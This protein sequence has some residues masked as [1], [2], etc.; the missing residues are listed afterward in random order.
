[1]AESMP[2][3]ETVSYGKFARRENDEAADVRWEHLLDDLPDI[4]ARV[5]RVYGM[6]PWTHRVT[7]ENEGEQESW[8]L[9]GFSPMTQLPD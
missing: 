7:F 3:R 1:M 5:E 6:L 8:L 4:E 9:R 2:L